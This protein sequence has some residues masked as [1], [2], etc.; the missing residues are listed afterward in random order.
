MPNNNGFYRD[1]FFYVVLLLLIGSFGWTTFV[2]WGLAQ[3]IAS[4]DTKAQILAQDTRDKAEALI[5]ENEEKALALAHYNEEQ[6]KEIRNEIKMVCE[7][8]QS[9]NEKTAT[10]LER[11]LTKLEIIEKKVQ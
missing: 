5:K 6:R 3:S 7:K 10:V 1:K 4:T 8:Q 11:I 9:T 2:G